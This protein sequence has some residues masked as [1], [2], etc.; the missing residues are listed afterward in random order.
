M[1]LLAALLVF[2]P[3]AALLAQRPAD[4]TID[5]AVAA[6]AKVKTARA[7][8][9]QTLTNPLTGNST[10][11]HGELQQQR[12]GRF[13]AR[14]SDPKG[15]V[16]VADGK[17]LWIYQPSSAPGQVIKL[18]LASA[19]GG[20]GVDLTDQLL[21]APRSKY[22]IASAGSLAIEGRAT[23]ALALTPKTQ[24]APFTRALV[25][26]DD[27][28]G[29]LRQF[30]V[31]DAT[32]LVRRVTLSKVRLNVPVDRDAFSFK[33]PKGVKVYDQAAMSGGTG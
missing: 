25:W 9:E 15:D 1:R 5:R 13:A 18:S 16:V 24:Q 22:T 32:G 4:E 3:G 7:S 31:T 19:G 17:T 30:E 29:T 14:F 2:A 23:T 6:Y 12:P 8:F 33:P 28:D 27:A 10:V 26:I 20:A 11:Q 21:L